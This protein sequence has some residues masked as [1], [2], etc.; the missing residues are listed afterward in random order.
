MQTNANAA[1]VVPIAKTCKE[2]KY[3]TYKCVCL[4]ILLLLSGRTI[5]SIQAT[6][7]YYYLIKPLTPDTK[8]LLKGPTLHLKSL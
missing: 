6:N 8:Y 3:K 2:Y 1:M 4:S 7:A 5:T